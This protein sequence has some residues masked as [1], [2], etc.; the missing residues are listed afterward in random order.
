M[1][2]DERTAETRTRTD[3]PAQAIKYV[4]PIEE[5]IRCPVALVS[6]SHE[7]DDAILVRG[8]ARRLPATKEQIGGNQR[9]DPQSYDHRRASYAR[10]AF[11]Q[12]VGLQ[13]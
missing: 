2:E 12:R 9:S 4:R 10:R 6:T 11:S 1:S 5:L 13:P 7:R 3:L 8:L